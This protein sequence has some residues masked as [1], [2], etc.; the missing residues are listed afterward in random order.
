MYVANIR[1]AHEGMFEALKV[2]GTIPFGYQGIPFPDTKNR[3]G[4]P[5]RVYAID[6]DEAEWVRQVFVWFVEDLGSV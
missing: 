3:K 5:H 2:H 1:S 4:N 6:P